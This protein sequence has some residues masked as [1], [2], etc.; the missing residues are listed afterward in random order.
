MQLVVLRCEQFL[1]WIHKV[2]NFYVRLFSTG[3]GSVVLSWCFWFQFC[4][5]LDGFSIWLE[6]LSCFPVLGHLFQGFY[7]SQE[8]SFGLVFRVGF[9]YSGWIMSLILRKFF[10]VLFTKCFVVVW[11]FPLSIESLW[12]FLLCSIKF[13]FHS[14]E[15]FVS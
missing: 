7:G 5:L 14:L 4:S 8:L 1:A 3:L 11:A 6:L 15:E 13:F 2:I 10:F 9:G 12:W